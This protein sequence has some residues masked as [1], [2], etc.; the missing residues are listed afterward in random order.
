MVTAIFKIV[1]PQ[2]EKIYAEAKSK[3]CGDH[4]YLRDQPFHLSVG[5]SLT[6]KLTLQIK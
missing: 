2:I 6:E 5:V 4:L 1:F 3:I